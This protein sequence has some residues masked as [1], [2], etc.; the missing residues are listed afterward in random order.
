MGQGLLF[1]LLLRDLKFSFVVVRGIEAVMVLNLTYFK[2]WR[3]LEG[4]R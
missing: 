4:L 1:W 3:A 2:K